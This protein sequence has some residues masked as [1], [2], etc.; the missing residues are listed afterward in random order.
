M[1][2]FIPC[3]LRKCCPSAI[4]RLIISIRVN[5]VNAVVVAWFTTHVVDKVFKTLRPSFTNRNPSSSVIHVL[6]VISIETSLLH[7]SPAVVFRRPGFVFGV[8]M[9]CHPG[10]SRLR[11]N[12]SAAFSFVI[13]Q[14][15]WNYFGFSSALALAHPKCLFVSYSRLIEN[16]RV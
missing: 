3:L 9:R 8:S 4:S 5:A 7:C 12:A 11:S 10:S 1:L 2:P 15:R 6:K 16:H 13:L 14:L